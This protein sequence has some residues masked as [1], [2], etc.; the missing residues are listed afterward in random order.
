MKHSSTYKCI[1]AAVLFI[2]L[3]CNTRIYAQSARDTLSEVKVKGKMHKHITNNDKINV[4]SPGQRVQGI[5]ST[6]LQQ[7]RLQSAANLLTQQVPVFVKTYGFNSL[8]T[9]N[10]R[11]ASPAQS[12]V[13]WNGIPIQN[14]SL[15]ITDISLL[16]LSLIDK[17]S[18]VYGSSSAMLGSGNVGGALLIENDIPHFDSARKYSLDI[19]GGVGSFGQN[20]LSIKSTYSDDRWYISAKVFDQAADNDFTYKSN[21]NVEEKLSNAKL[22]GAG[23]LLN[24][25]YKISDYSTIGF[26]AWYQQYD[27]QIPPALFESISL[28]AQMD[29]SLRLMLDWQRHKD[30]TKWYAKTAFIQDGIEFNDNAIGILSISHTQQYFQELGWEWQTLHHKF[31]IFSP[32]QFSSIDRPELQDTKQQTKVALASAYAFTTLHEKLN[33]AVNLRGE[34]IN[35]LSVA[36]PGLNASYQILPCI[37]LRA[38]AQRTYRAPTLN[39][40]YFVP[41]GNTSLKPEQGWNYD[42]GYSLKV[43]LT[44]DITL[45]HD[46]AIFDRLIH[47]WIIWLGAPIL[48]PHNIATVHSHGTETESK[49]QWQLAKWQLHLGLNSSYVLATTQSSYI[50]GDGSI[51]K[52]IPYTPHY[53]GQLNVGFTFHGLYLNYNHTFTGY[54]YVTA[55]E[56]QYLSDYSTG[57]VQLMYNIHM[58]KHPI[59]F[60]IQCNN[61]WDQ[62]Y[63]VVAY[64]PMPGINWLAGL[65][66]NLF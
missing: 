23:G 47:D 53:N 60:N 46:A 16:P 21:K 26:T 25:A 3:L 24:V 1:Y 14:A 28:K 36:L 38:N 62:H 29:N 18:M 11:G 39:E 19:N 31:M 55:D 20:Q 66:L 54:R 41:W 27:R 9:F 50:T 13:L 58:H 12:Q 8:A 45:I 17:V 43:K 65:Q 34:S 33:I 49:L 61:I 56:S 35:D 5:D 57:N 15:G 6:T 7:Y 10:I 2:A 63:Q 42:A 59:R 51:G 48:T 30:R 4:F 22:H 40:L 64:R 44:E 37:L 52:Q 32:L